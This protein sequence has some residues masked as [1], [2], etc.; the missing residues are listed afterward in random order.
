MQSSEHIH[1]YG[2]LCGKIGIVIAFGPLAG[3]I[4]SNLWSDYST[5]NGSSDSVRQIKIKVPDSWPSYTAYAYTFGGQA[6]RLAVVGTSK[7]N[8]K[9]N[10][11]IGP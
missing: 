4:T 8:P 9:F 11:S 1:P 5:L 7:E 6:M 10:L 2:D 3:P